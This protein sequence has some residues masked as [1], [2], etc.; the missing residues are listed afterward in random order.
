M[1]VL[2]VGSGG[3]EHAIAWALAQSS[4]I[5]RLFVAPGNAGTARIADNIPIAA[6]D[7][8]ALLKFARDNDVEFV[9]VGPEQPIA[10]GIQQ[11]FSEA[12][13][14]CLAPTPDAAQLEASKVW[15]KRFME[16]HEI[17]TAFFQVVTSPEEIPAVVERWQPPV[18]VKADGLAGGKGAFILR[19]R[20][21]LET[22]LRDLLE[23][24]VLGE[25]GKRVVVERFLQGREVS[26][27]VIS[28]GRM[29]RHLGEARDYKRLRDGDE[30]PNTGGM[31]ALSPVPDFTPEERAQV[32]EDVVFPTFEGLRKEGVAYVGFL[33][34]GLMLTDQGPFMLEY[35]V[36]LGD[37]EAQVLLPRLRGDF[38][39]LLLMAHE[40]R[41]EEAFHEMDTEVQAVGVV[42]AS[43]GY[44]TRPV[45]GRVI[46]GLED[47]EAVEGVVIFHAGTRLEEGRV[48]TSGGRVLTVVGLGRDRE[49]ARKRA[50]TAISKIH[51]DGMQYRKDIGQP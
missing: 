13:I 36:R 25:A 51:F 37:P 24:G 47:A 6:T 41:L 3:R 48:V 46:E 50:Y 44:P 45:T 43:E 14:A 39:K 17:P 31:G 28:D 20:Q 7:V 26:L 12:G 34:F 2:V 5:R 35:N 4:G 29:F 21:E 10:L 19:S 1:N 15:A 23:G 33:Y 22:T 49:E 16:R 32:Y 30:G 38:L 11:A 40:G 27:F 18:V 42:V 9:V 8:E